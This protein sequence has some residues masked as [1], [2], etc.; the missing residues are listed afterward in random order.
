MSDVKPWPIHP[1]ETYPPEFNANSDQWRAALHDYERA[2]ADAA[3]SR[4]RVAVEALET[5]LAQ[6]S[7]VAGSTTLPDCMATVARIALYAIG[8]LP[9]EQKGE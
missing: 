4:L 6:H 3:M 2:R 8:P 5:L 1:R 9:P 7:G